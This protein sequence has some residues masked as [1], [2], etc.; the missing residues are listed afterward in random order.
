MA[1]IKC[2]ARYRALLESYESK[3]GFARAPI[4]YEAFTASRDGSV[5]WWES[6]NA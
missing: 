6:A 3:Y 1:L 5:P 2:N 4:R